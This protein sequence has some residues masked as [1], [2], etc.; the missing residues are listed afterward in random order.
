MTTMNISLPEEMKAF[1]ESEMAREGF[2]SASEYLRSLIREA[3]KQRARQELEARLL[4]GLQGPVV[5]MTAED[6]D[7]ME[8]EALG[9]AGRGQA[10]S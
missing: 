5:E 9:R 10:A 4:E 7:S 1:V 3:Q 2:A 6:W 8:R